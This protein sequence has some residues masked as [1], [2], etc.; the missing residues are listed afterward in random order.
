MNEADLPGSGL[1]VIAAA[2]LL[3]GQFFVL[4]AAHLAIQ[5]VPRSDVAAGSSR[6]NHGE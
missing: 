6:T 2:V 3:V 4:A 5:Q 1:V